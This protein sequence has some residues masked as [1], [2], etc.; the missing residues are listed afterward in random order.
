LKKDNRGRKTVVNG[1]QKGISKESAA[2]ISTMEMAQEQRKNL[3]PVGVK[4]RLE[5]YEQML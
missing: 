1:G 3:D 5:D 2:H 4:K